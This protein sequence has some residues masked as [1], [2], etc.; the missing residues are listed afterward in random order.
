ML[1]KR[2]ESF[3]DLR[4]VQV[5]MDRVRKYVVCPTSVWP[6]LWAINGHVDID[7]YDRD[8]NLVVRAS[9]PGVKPDELDVT[10][11]EDTLTIKGESRFGSEVKEEEYLHR[12]HLLGS[13]DRTVA[14]P[15]GLATAEANATFENGI[16]T[17][18]IPHSAESKP[19]SLK[20]N[21]RGANVRK[22]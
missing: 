7:V 3:N 17:V 11:T 20:I 14:L 16:L 15:Q 13:F 22:K 12:E 6:R 10:V 8:D 2:W 1:L 21:V 4:K 18:A 9:V 5:D 19:K